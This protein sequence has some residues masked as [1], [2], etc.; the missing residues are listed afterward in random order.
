MRP[1]STTTSWPVT[2]SFSM[3]A[4]TARA[5]WSGAATAFKGVLSAVDDR[6]FHLAQLGRRRAAAVE[7]ALEVDAQDL[8]P[9]GVGERV[10]V[11]MWDEVGGAGVVDQDVE[12]AE[13]LH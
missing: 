9:H 2:R 3:N 11:G 10:Q 6:A 4:I 5:T 1:P 7:R 12:T 8:V 13:P